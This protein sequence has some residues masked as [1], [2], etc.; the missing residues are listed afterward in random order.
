MEKYQDD[1]NERKYFAKLQHNDK[2]W[3][4]RQQA[5]LNTGMILPFSQDDLSGFKA[6]MQLPN[7]LDS[8]TVSTTVA[9]YY[10]AWYT[11]VPIASYQSL[12]HLP[13][14]NGDMWCILKFDSL[15][16]TRIKVGIVFNHTVNGSVFPAPRTGAASMLQG[17]SF[18]Y[19]NDTGVVSAGALFKNWNK[20]RIYNGSQLFLRIDSFHNCY[21]GTSPSD[22][23]LVFNI[24]SQYNAATC[25]T[26]KISFECYATA[27][28]ET[29]TISLLDSGYNYPNEIIYPATGCLCQSFSPSLAALSSTATSTLFP[30][31]DVAIGSNEKGALPTRLMYSFKLVANTS[32]KILLGVLSP[33]AGLTT[34]VNSKNYASE[35]LAKAVYVI[36]ADSSDNSVRLGDGSLVWSDAIEGFGLV[37]TVI[38]IDLIYDRSSGESLIRFGNSRSSFKYTYSTLSPVLGLGGTLLGLTT[39][40]F[41]IV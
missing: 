25:S 41:N 29:N 20:Y 16:S 27:A 13:I 32:T 40:Q 10:H 4:L 19:D 38:S 3:N 28:V 23:A 18:I 9:T 30:Y 11:N 12:N 1:H 36:Y 34:A 2:A 7:F 33:T 26:P 8:M 17:K 21:I 14:P 5:I 37:N 22:A 39:V 31:T 24:A 15:V 6:K 35:A